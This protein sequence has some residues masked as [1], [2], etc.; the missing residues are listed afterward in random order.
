MGA[1]FTWLGSWLS[2][3][4]AALVCLVKAAVQ[5]IQDA[6]KDLFYWV[7]DRLLEFGGWV[8]SGLDVGIS[9]FSPATYFS[10]LPAEVVAVIGVIGL[11]EAVAIIVA[12]IVIRIALQSIPFVRWGS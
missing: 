2:S 8:L 9:A 10:A 12:A 3:F 1:F 11:A 4:W 7:V 5:S 6:F